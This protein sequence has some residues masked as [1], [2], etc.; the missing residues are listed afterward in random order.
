MSG[1]RGKRPAGSRYDPVR[2][3]RVSD[4]TWE[5]A[6]RRALYEGVTMSH[7]LLTILEGYSKGLIDLPRVTVSYRPPKDD[8]SVS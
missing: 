2:S 1:V 3:V 8:A 6:R 7:V 5:A 4:A